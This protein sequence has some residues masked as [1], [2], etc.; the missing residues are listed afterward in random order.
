MENRRN[1]IKKTAAVAAFSLVADRAFA[2]FGIDKWVEILPQ[3]LVK[4]TA[5][6]VNNDMDAGF[7]L[8]PSSAKP[9]VY[10]FWI[11][12]NI[13][14]EG[15]TADLE[16]MASVGIEGVLIFECAYNSPLGTVDTMSSQWRDMFKHSLTEAN[17][18]GLE[19]AINNGPGWTGSGGP[20]NRPED[21]MK[22]LVS[23]TTVIE[24]GKQFDGILAKPNERYGVYHDIAV[25]A[26]PLPS[27]VS[28]FP[29]LRA[30]SMTEG[31]P[32]SLVQ[33][34]SKTTRWVSSGNGPG[35]GPTRESPEYLQF[36]YEDVWKAKG[37]Y[38]VPYT[39]CGPK[40]IEVQYSVDGQNYQ[41]IKQATLEKGEDA[42][43]AFDNEIEAKYFRVVFYSAHDYYGDASYNVQVAEARLMTK[44]DF[45]KKDRDGIVED[46][47]DKSRS[48]E[49]TEKMSSEGRLEWDVP[50]GKWALMRIGY[51]STGRRNDPSTEA[52]SGLECDKLDKQALEK[53]FE[54]MLGKLIEDAGSLTGDVFT[55]AHIDSWEVGNQ[56]WT[57][58]FREEFKHLRGYD[59][60]HFLPAEFNRVVDNPEISERFEWDMQITINQMLL[61]NYAAHMKQLANNNNLKLSTE[62]IGHG[63]FV[64][65]MYAGRVDLPMGEFWTHGG[66]MAWCKEMASASHVYGKPITGAEA[67]TSLPDQAKF[68]RH[69]YLYKTLND[70]AFCEGINKLY[71]HLYTHQPFL[72]RAPGMTM[73]GFGAHY[74]RNQVWWQ[75][76][77]AWHQYLSRCQYLLQS[78]LFVADICYL[79]VETSPRRAPYARQN[80]LSPSLPD[81]Y[82][83]D[84]FPAE[85]L[86]IRMSVENGRIVLPDGMS[87]RLM[88]LPPTTKITPETLA[89]VRDMVKA[90]A[91]VVATVRPKQSPSLENYPT[92]DEQVAQLADEL[93]GSSAIPSDGIIS[94]DFGNGKVLLTKNLF[95]AV[96]SI[97]LKADFNVENFRATGTLG[98]F[99]RKNFDP[100]IPI[101]WIHRKINSEDYY[102]ISNQ[103]KNDVQFDGVFRVE[104]KQPE[105]WHPE[106]S[107]VKNLP[108]FTQE[109]R[110]VRVPLTLGPAESVFVVFRN[111]A[112][113]NL[114]GENWSGFKALDEVNGPW[115]VTFDEQKG[116][117]NNPT[118]FPNP[119]VFASLEDWSLSDENG[120]KY[121]SGRATYQKDL[122]ISEQTL[123]S[124]S[125]I[126]LN[127]GRVEVIASVKIN[128][129]EV[130]TLWKPPFRTDVT[131]YLVAGTN[132]LEVSV[133]NVW[134]NRLVGDEQLPQDSQWRDEVVM[135]NHYRVLV[136]WP[137]WLLEGNPSPTGRRT[138][139]TVRYHS[140]DE[141][142]IPSGLLGPVILEVETD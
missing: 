1:F 104:D 60:L 77:E 14:E 58:D 93:F 26:S 22:Q 74:N 92:C 114:T 86:L 110:C 107:V 106:T 5:N 123:L 8:P 90:G 68:D 105:L 73:G 10:W 72:D 4:S 130:A 103:T 109:G 98:W 3:R 127:L 81:G 88:V 75:E 47:W 124:N 41:L 96:D 40:D 28:P 82:D 62:A 9:W 24:G 66:G 64:D 132:S 65:Q 91:T 11:N 95:K 52:G 69:P 85:V 46:S 38:L 125:K 120:I 53:H 70:Y 43:I 27:T 34:G 25:L 122:D 35:Q 16:A 87:Y 80:E 79:D 78:G 136:D 36:D 15:I 33:D 61:D 131:S 49:L 2:V 50:A 31:Y 84:V 101:R 45:V 23:T 21:S 137:D 138:F 97:N 59:P 119:T 135:D 94:R 19:V 39:D 133:V 116:N 100:G 56:N 12:G 18:L 55:Y 6:N 128:G 51:T 89:R 141:V 76:S 129:E 112:P 108:D 17:R 44:Q 83:Y 140:P 142:L 134:H 42:S 32:A 30:S 126:Y 63:P 7:I 37:L 111:P 54:G 117:P 67:Y 20:W 13:T 115:I 102:F 121:F 118:T 113:D 99:E 29:N 139:S 48:I 57:V 71:I